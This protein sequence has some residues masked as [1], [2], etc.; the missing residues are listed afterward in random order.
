M[1]VYS[2]GL[3]N[4]LEFKG[5]KIHF[6]WEQRIRN[7]LSSLFGRVICI[8]CYALLPRYWPMKIIGQLGVKCAA[9][10]TKDIHLALGWLQNTLKLVLGNFADFILISLAG[11]VSM[12][13]KDA[14]QHLAEISILCLNLFCQMNRRHLTFSY[15]NNYLWRNEDFKISKSDDWYSLYYDHCN[16]IYFEN[17]LVLFV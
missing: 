11:L 8:I 14:V 6:G 1:F 16:D 5:S 3:A 9:K 15:R 2:F 7:E 13:W 4:D 17:K 12:C 10:W